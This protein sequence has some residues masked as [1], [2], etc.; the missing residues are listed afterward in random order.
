[1]ISINNLNACNYIQEIHIFQ[2]L[3]LVYF[4]CMPLSEDNIGIQK[5]EENNSQ[6]TLCIVIHRVTYNVINT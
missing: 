4:S 2:T 3:N 5:F 1:M 6:V